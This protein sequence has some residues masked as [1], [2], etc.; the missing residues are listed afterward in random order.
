MFLPRG[1]PDQ[2]VRLV[3]K[4]MWNPDRLSYDDIVD[5]YCR[6]GFGE[7]AP[8]I[9]AYF[10]L[11]EKIFDEAAA[12]ACDYCEAYTLEKIDALEK[13]LNDAEN[14]TADADIK[15]RV[16]FLKQGLEIGRFATKLY[17]AKKNKDKNYR[18][19]QKEYRAYLQKLAVESPLAYSPGSLG[20]NTRFLVR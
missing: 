5:D 14:S 11:M 7:A 20:F 4:A 16:Q 1:D 15:A 12:K 2:S 10:D 8:K 3:S 6:A 19:I 18:T 13:I 17:N 9:K